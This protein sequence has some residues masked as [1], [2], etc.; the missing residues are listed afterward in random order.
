MAI[1]FRSDRSNVEVP[2]EEVSTL[3]LAGPIKGMTGRPAVH[4]TKP[5]ALAL[6]KWLGFEI[7]RVDVETVPGPEP[8][9]DAG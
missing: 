1:R 3:R 7:N 8:V 5:E 9:R 6:A 2:D 4:L